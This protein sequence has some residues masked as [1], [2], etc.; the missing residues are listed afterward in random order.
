[1]RADTPSP[2]SAVALAKGKRRH[3]LTPHLVHP[4]NPVN[5]SMKSL[6]L[7]S[8]SAPPRELISAG[9]WRVPRSLRTCSPPMNQTW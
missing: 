8:L 9:S 4:V 5:N 7:Y 2:L 6:T 1:M 3:N